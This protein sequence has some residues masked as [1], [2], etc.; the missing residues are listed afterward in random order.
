MFYRLQTPVKQK[1][2]TGIIVPIQ[3]SRTEDPFEQ[4]MSTQIIVS[5]IIQGTEMIIDEDELFEKVAEM[6]DILDQQENNSN[7]ESNIKNYIGKTGHGNQK[8]NQG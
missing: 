3:W 2:I 1:G 8:P 7:L 5:G 6:N 4:F